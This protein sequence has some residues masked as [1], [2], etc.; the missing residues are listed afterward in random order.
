MAKSPLFSRVAGRPVT[1]KSGGLTA[2]RAVT[3]ERGWRD[4]IAA[5]PANRRHTALRDEVRGL[6]ARVLGAARGSVNLEDP[7]RDLGLDSLM[8]V[9]LRNRLGAAVERA[10]PATIT[11]DCPTTASLIAYLI[12]EGIVEVDEPDA[13]GADQADDGYENQTEDQLSS[14]LAAKLDGLKLLS[15]MG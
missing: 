8:A 5:L 11:F 13:A 4:R 9:E 7:L 14:A 12:D 3:E 2:T 15:E 1:D 6:V 10:L